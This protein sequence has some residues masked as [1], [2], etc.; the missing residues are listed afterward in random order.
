M[1][2]DRSKLAPVTGN[3]QERYIE[4]NEYAE[5]LLVKLKM[6]GGVSLAEHP[7]TDAIGYVVGDKHGTVHKIHKVRKGVFVTSNW[8]FLMG[9]KSQYLYPDAKWQVNPSRINWFL[10]GG[11]NARQ[12]K[13]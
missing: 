8:R 10:N 9:K 6:L 4:D 7:Y 12:N 1:K 5:T 11:W 2:L 3:F 13:T